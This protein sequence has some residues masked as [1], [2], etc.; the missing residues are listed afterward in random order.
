MILAALTPAAWYL[1]KDWTTVIPAVV[2]GVVG[3][4]WT[5]GVVKSA[6]AAG[7]TEE[8]LAR[9]ASRAGVRVAE[10]GEL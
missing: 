10:L 7:P 1:F 9:L 3:S 5:H 6:G 4:R 8:A 2:A